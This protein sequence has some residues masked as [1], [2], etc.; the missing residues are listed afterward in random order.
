MI[1]IVSSD[2]PD[3][4]Y[5]WGFQLFA[6]PEWDLRKD[7]RVCLDLWEKRG[8][9]FSPNMM[10]SH[11]P[12]AGMEDAKQSGILSG[13]RSEGDEIHNMGIIFS[14]HFMFRKAESHN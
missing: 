2:G 13:R 6:R 4:T 8:T 3:T 12:R 7:P 11:I 5:V 1:E 9:P 14:H 10:L